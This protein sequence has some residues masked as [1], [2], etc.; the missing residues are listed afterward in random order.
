MSAPPNDEGSSGRKIGT[1]FPPTPQPTGIQQHRHHAEVEEEQP[2]MRAVGIRSC[3]EPSLVSNF[4]RFAS[5][6]K[7]APQP[8]ALGIV[9]PSFGGLKP[10]APCSRST[11]V[12]VQKEWTGVTWNVKPDDLELLP[13]DF[14][15]ERTHREIEGSDA[16][17][18]A[19][20]ISDALRDLSI[21]A[22]YDDR[23]AKA[24]CT[25][26]ECVRFRIRLF[27]GGE[28]GQ[29]VVV[30]L[31]RRSGSA[32][33]FMHSCRAIL[34]SAE[35]MKTTTTATSLGTTFTNAM[36]RKTNLPPFM[37]KQPVADMKCLQNVVL[38]TPSPV[39]LAREVSDQ[40]LKMLRPKLRDSSI[41]ALE[42]LCCLTDPVKTSPPVAL[43]V[44]K[45]VALGDDKYEL[46]EELRALMDRDVF[47]E[48]AGGV[49]D[50]D[51]SAVRYKEQVRLLVFRAFANALGMCSNHGCLVD[52]VQEQTWFTEDLIPA[53]VDELKM[54]SSSMCIANE[55]ASSL[56]CLVVC[57]ERA[58]K[59]FVEDHGGIEILQRANQY[60]TECHALLAE[61]TQRCLSALN[62][63]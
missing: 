46:R 45:L 5:V 2:S 34:N 16:T 53:L 48:N 37:T 12:T 31:Q 24:K 51:E 40:V 19:N 59:H 33:A 50:E 56:Y 62:A 13:L 29:P 8:S 25:T 20:R 21:D 7:T 47:D 60:G 44:C 6:G 3:T 52:A 14:P 18:V 41:L 22:D 61:E 15:L 4:D 1:F 63:A 30:E 58:R 38:K 43:H 32:S 26:C 42:N 9:R 55:A 49:V 35:G 23:K 27:S 36:G 11:S 39:D 28:G 54:A 17:Q 10:L 57:S